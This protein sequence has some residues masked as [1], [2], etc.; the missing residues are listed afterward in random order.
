MNVVGW[1]S[2]GLQRDH[3][4][5]QTGQLFALSCTESQSLLSS[6]TSLLLR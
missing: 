1:V 6:L 3:N 2:D 5:L 4:Y